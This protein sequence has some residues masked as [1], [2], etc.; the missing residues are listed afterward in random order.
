MSEEIWMKL[1][2]S[3]TADWMKRKKKTLS[4][5]YGIMPLAATKRGLA[6]G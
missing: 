5:S 6:Y 3:K 2:L 4:N 1:L